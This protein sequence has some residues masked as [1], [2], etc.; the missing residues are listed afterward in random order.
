M[1]TPVKWTLMSEKHHELKVA[2]DE[3]VA[4]FYRFEC[5]MS[6][7]NDML[8][9]IKRKNISLKRASLE[10]V[11]LNILK[12]VRFT[13]RKLPRGTRYVDAF[14]KCVN[15]KFTSE[16]ISLYPIMAELVTRFKK[17]KELIEK[18]YIKTS[19]Y[20]SFA[21]VPSVHKKKATEGDTWRAFESYV[22]AMEQEPKSRGEQD[23]G[24]TAVTEGHKV[25][26]ADLLDTLLSFQ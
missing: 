19:L 18:Y 17:A 15:E 4:Q 26:V 7:L 23:A 3:Y 13:F 22:D 12:Y 20:T 21:E 5:A 11:M 9:D 25:Q 14:G 16:V 6:C 10:V 1:D 24:P 2:I 8:A